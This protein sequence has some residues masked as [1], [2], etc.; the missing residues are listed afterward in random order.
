MEGDEVFHFDRIVPV[1]TAPEGLNERLLRT[2]IGRV[3]SAKPRFEDPIPPAIRQKWQ[4]REKSWAIQKIHFPDTL[5]QKEEARQVLAFEE[6]LILEAALGLVRHRIKQEMKPQR[7][8]LH[9]TLLTPFRQKLGFEF[10]SAQKRVI[11]EIF[12][13]MMKPQPMNRLLQGDVGSG[14]TLAALSAMLLAVENGGQAVLMAPTE[15]L[16]EQHALT[17]SRFLKHLPVQCALLTGS[18]ASAQRRHCLKEIAEGRVHLV[19]GTHALVQK[20]VQFASLQLAVI[21]EQH[22]FGV[23]HRRLLRKK[24]SCPDI[25]VM[26]ATPIPRTL[27]LTV[28]GDL[29]VSVIDELP[30]GRTPVITRHVAEEEAYRQVQDA[31]RQGRQAYIVYPLVTESDKVELKAVTQEAIALSRTVFKESSRGSP[32][33]SAFRT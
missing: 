9:K 23:E 26:T 20:P 8:L 25:L 33:R 28:Y 32:S 3:L 7:Y 12:D 17:I 13:D 6:F 2:L 19:I 11:R 18:Q 31:V 15:I 16:A 29:D 24:G 21:D 30:P 4:I 10:T 22:R 14:K 5:I 1:Y 27:A